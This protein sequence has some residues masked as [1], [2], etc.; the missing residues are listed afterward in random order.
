MNQALNSDEVLAVAYQ[1]TING[2]PYQV[3]EFSNQLSSPDVL[4]LKLLKST[5]IDIS[6]PMWK[7]QMKN[8]YSLGAYQVNQEDFNL[9]ILYQDDDSGIP[10]QYIPEEGMS[11]SLIHI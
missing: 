6:L 7:L 9:Q 2:I 3:G 8:V 1:Y 4:I 11:L 10:I 5:I